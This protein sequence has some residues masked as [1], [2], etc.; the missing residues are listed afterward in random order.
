MVKSVAAAQRY[1]IL[2][3]MTGATS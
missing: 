3:E 2:P 1:D